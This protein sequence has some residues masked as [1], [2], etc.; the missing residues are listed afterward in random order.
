MTSEDR[1]KEFVEMIRTAYLDQFQ[2]EVDPSLLDFYR[3]I[4]LMGVLEERHAWN[5]RTQKQAHK[6]RMRWTTLVILS[7]L[8]NLGMALAN[9]VRLLP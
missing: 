5:M 8:L 4:Y 2:H 9:L 7:C 1:A 6:R 3:R